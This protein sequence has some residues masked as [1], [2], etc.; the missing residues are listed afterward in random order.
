MQRQ[1][2]SALIRMALSADT[3]KSVD[4]APSPVVGSLAELP[5]PDLLRALARTETSGMLK[6][7]EASPTWVALAAGAVVIAGGASTPSL[8]DELLHAGALDESV[9]HEAVSRGAHHDLTLLCELAGDSPSERL[10]ETVREHTVAAVFQLLLPSTDPFAFQPGAPI[11]VAR[12]VSF[13][14][15][16]I[17]SLAQQRLERWAEVAATVPST[18]LVFHVRR[19]LDASIEEVTVSRADWQ[20]LAVLD[21]RRTVAQVIAATG[22]SGFDV[23]S[24]LHQFVEAGLIETRSGQGTIPRTDR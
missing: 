3:V 9:I 24:T 1:S 4:A 20:I 18:Q 23:L 5:G 13:P 8:A 21:G 22:R 2:P 6:V 16:V 10:I 11:S 12:H 7:G 17:L 19:L 14:V 15:E